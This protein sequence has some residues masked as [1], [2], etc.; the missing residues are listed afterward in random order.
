M[1]WLHLYIFSF[2]S[3]VNLDIH[4][5]AGTVKDTATRA[6]GNMGRLAVSSK[7]SLWKK[8]SEA[9]NYVDFSGLEAGL[10]Q[11]FITFFVGKDHLETLSSTFQEYFLAHVT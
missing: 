6:E 5:L 3:H 4:S 7:L 9:H 1:F 8:S 10:R 11:A 2:I